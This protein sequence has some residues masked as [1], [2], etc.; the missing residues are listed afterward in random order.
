MTDEEILL[1]ARAGGG[2]LS[3]R[4]G[5]GGRA[6]GMRLRPLLYALLGALTTSVLWVLSALIF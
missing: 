3:A 1:Q 2:R 4:P 6:R 5:T